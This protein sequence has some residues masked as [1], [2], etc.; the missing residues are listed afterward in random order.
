MEELHTYLCLN[1][2]GLKFELWL[3]V[4]VGK[5]LCLG[6]FCISKHTVLCSVPYN[7]S[8]AF[9][10]VIVTRFFLFFFDKRTGAF[11][12]FPQLSY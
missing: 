2:S 11:N 3:K 9:Q 7:S 8:R 12:R 6:S 10:G 4:E 5:S 1:S